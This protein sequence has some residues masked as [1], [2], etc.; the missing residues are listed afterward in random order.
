M[1]RK[2]KIFHCQVVT[3][4]YTS[5]N[6]SDEQIFSSL[7]SKNSNNSNV[8]RRQKFLLEKKTR[9]HYYHHSIISFYL[10]LLAREIEECVES[11]K[12]R[13]EF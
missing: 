7:F 13:I 5:K 3:L 11:K 4:C 2:G 9:P 10:Q 1:Q 12:T 6:W 8:N